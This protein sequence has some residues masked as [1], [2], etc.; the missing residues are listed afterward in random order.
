MPYVKND[1][2]CIAFSYARYVKAMEE[3]TGFSVKDCLS[4]PDLGLK[5]FSSLRTEEG[6]SIFAY[7]EKYMRQIVRQA[8]Y[9]G[10]VCAFNQN[11]KS[12]SC[13]DILKNLSEELNVEGNVYDKNRSLYEL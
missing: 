1:V 13:D 6:E 7:N 3:I 4:L 12:Q 5:Y 8:A 2:L 11:Y 10:R 9:G